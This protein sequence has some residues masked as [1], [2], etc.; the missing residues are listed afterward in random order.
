MHVP[1][2]IS[3]IKHLNYLLIL[4]HLRFR[5]EKNWRYVLAEC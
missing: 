5:K 4:T 2:Y 1:T 3:K